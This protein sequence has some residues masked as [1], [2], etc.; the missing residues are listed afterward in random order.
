MTQDHGLPNISEDCL[1]ETSHAVP[2]APFRHRDT[3][4][5]PISQTRDNIFFSQT[6]VV[7]ATF[8]VR[9]RNDLPVTG[10]LVKG[11]SNSIPTRTQAGALVIQSQHGTPGIPGVSLTTESTPAM[12]TIQTDFLVTK[13]TYDTLITT[14]TGALVTAVPYSTPTMSRTTTLLT[15]VQIRS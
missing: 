6:A 3:S 1:A 7:V 5:N 8:D 14:Q 4:V 15:K 11:S 13:S 9:S 12:P 2:A 10:V